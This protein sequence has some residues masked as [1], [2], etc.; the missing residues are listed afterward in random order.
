MITTSSNVSILLDE[1]EIREAIFNHL[2]RLQML[3]SGTLDM[4]DIK[5]LTHVDGQ[6]VQTDVSAQITYNVVTT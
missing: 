5:I 4:G 1:N 6:R 3:P 2:L